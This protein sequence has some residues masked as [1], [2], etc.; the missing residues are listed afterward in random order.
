MGRIKAQSMSRGVLI[1][2]GFLVHPMPNVFILFLS[3]S[4][5]LLYFF[6]GHYVADFFSSF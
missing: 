6:S 3:D 2:L 5:F 4:L 1:F